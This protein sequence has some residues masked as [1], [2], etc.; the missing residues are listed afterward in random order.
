MPV[1]KPKVLL[2]THTPNA[3]ALVY[4]AYRQC[5]HAGF[6]GD[7]WDK[8]ITDDP[9]AQAE[10][11]ALVLKSGHESPI[12]HVSF[13]FAVSGVSRALT[14]QLVRHRIASYSQQS[15]RYVNGS[16]FDY[17][18]PPSIAKNAAAKLKFEQA[19]AQI[20]TAYQEIHE[21]L[22]VD[23]AHG[24][25]AHEDARFVLPQAAASNIVITMNAR[26]LLNFFEHRTCRR[27]QW[28]IQALAGSM[29]K[30]CCESLPQ[31]FA[32]AGPKC[33]RLGY[34]PEGPKFSC[35]LYPCK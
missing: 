20:A 1:V 13:S 4:A 21:F 33:Q 9:T 32:Q 28:E 3:L 30:L 34:C 12:E 29:L 10:F 23:G 7:L 19:M 16:H 6:I 35:G 31:I 27:A 18:L 17:V 24:P 8:L 22:E 14:H 2:L 11:I 5:Y 25:K 26:A 15:Q